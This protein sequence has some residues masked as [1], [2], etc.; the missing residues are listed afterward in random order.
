LFGIPP[1]KAQTD[2]IC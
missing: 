2:C 1:L